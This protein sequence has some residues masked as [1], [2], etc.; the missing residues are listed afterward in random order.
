MRSR[1][2]TVLGEYIKVDTRRCV[3]D[4]EASRNLVDNLNRQIVRLV[5]CILKHYL[6]RRDE[7][8]SGVSW[9]YARDSALSPSMAYMVHACNSGA[10]R[11]VSFAILPAPAS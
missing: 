10:M 2:G 6:Y 4:D 7:Q 3:K 11:L 8:A 9:R 1:G 5:Q